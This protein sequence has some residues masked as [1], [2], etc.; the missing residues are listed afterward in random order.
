MKNS[1][2]GIAKPAKNKI[3][4]TKTSTPPLR[5]SRQEN[6]YTEKF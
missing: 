6:K 1:F 4:K 2:V 5:L 3:S